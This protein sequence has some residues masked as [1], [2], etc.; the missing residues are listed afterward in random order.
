MIPV[1]IDIAKQKIDIYYE[2]QHYIIEN[3]EKAL[4]KFFKQL[5]KESKI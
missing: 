2:K 1:G 4:R 5:P 3:S